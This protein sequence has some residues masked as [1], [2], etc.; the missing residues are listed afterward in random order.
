MPIVLGALVYRFELDGAEVSWELLDASL[1]EALHELPLAWFDVLVTGSLPPKMVGR[2]LRFE[3]SRVEVPGD[4]PLVRAGLVVRVE[5]MHRVLDG[6]FRARIH[7]SSKGFKLGIGRKTRIFRDM[8]A[9][10]VIT[11]V[12]SEAGLGGVNVKSTA[13][14][15][16]YTTQYFETDHDFIRRLVEDYGLV[17][18]WKPDDDGVYIGAVGGE[19]TE[20]V[21]RFT[22]IHPLDAPLFAGE[23]VY[24]F[25]QESRLAVDKVQA[26]GWDPKTKKAVLGVAAVTGAQKGFG[27]E[28]VD[29]A[30]EGVRGTPWALMA[31]DAAAKAMG[32][33]DDAATELYRGESDLRAITA[34]RSIEIDDTTDSDCAGKYCVTRVQHRITLADAQEGGGE[35]QVV[36]RNEFECVAER[37]PCRPARVVP[38]PMALAPAIAVVTAIPHETASKLGAMEV[39]VTF[40]TFNTNPMNVWLRLAQPFAGPTHGFQFLPH[41]NDEVIVH[42]LDG[43]PD[44]PV[45]IGALYNGVDKPPAELPASHTRNV[46]RAAPYHPGEKFSGPDELYFE[47][48]AS[49]RIVGIN[50]AE[51]HVI[52]VGNDTTLHTARDRSTTVDRDD[53]HTVK[54]AMTVEVTKDRTTTVK[55]NDKTTVEKNH[56]QMVKQGSKVTVF[57][58]LVMSADEGI[59]LQCGDNSIVITPGG[60]T[61]SIASGPKVE[62]KGANVTVE[63]GSG[64]KVELKPATITVENGSGA[65]VELVGPQ[66][67]LN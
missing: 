58:K 2:A 62:L 40:P 14:V 45:V 7:L 38:R 9:S 26:I 49:R 18:R 30:P 31:G 35:R 54:G 4:V 23:S 32:T 36:Y 41:I 34:G 1:D 33:V 19:E 16:E 66:L 64:A 13:H 61:L 42:W 59:E 67:N 53:K 50:A 39:E 11:K 22:L 56:E 46:I 6:R 24:G 43:D 17:L 65:K 52:E 25:V 51:D 15:R 10:D 3:L 63:N 48:D 20:S 12:L 44:R 27:A 5:A 29:L 8:T 55:G 47:E 37:F 57:K 28:L 21:G 60:I